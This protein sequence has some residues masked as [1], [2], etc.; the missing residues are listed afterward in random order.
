MGAM[1]RHLVIPLSVLCCLLLGHRI[2]AQTCECSGREAHGLMGA[3]VVFTGRVT[4]IT[5]DPEGRRTIHFKAQR[6]F[7]GEVEPEMSVRDS[8]AGRCQWPFQVGHAYLVY[9]YAHPMDDPKAQ[10]L[11]SSRCDPNLDLASPQADARLRE[12][13][14][15]VVHARQNPLE[16]HFSGR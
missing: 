5:S 12:L 6:R 1:S 11:F 8:L 10:G 2:V 15:Y 7:W 3:S 13:T 14:D 9:G 4:A 16:Y